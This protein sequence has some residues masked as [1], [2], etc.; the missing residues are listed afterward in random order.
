V[1]PSAKRQAIAILVD[2]HRVS[3]RRACQVVR[4]ARAAY[5]RPP[6]AAV[7][8]DAAVIEALTSLVARKPRWGFWK[9]FD[10]FHNQG[11]LWNHKRVYRVYCA[12]RLNLARR[13]KKRVPTRV[14]Q[15]LGAPAFVN[16][17]WA[18]DFMHD[19]LYDSRPFRTFNVLDEGNREA[20]A[21][22]VA[23][24]L[25]SWRVLAVLDELIAVHGA[26]AA[27]RLDNGPEFIAEAVAVWAAAQGIAL[28]FIQPG[29][30]DQNAYIERFNRTYREE[31]LDAHVFDSIGE[32]QAET[33]L[34]RQSYNTERPHDSLG[35]RPPLIFLPRSTS[36]SESTS[37]VST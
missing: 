10:R 9:C 23:T 32:V 21:I 17:T 15:P 31:V 4:L 24:S 14:R 30:P 1:T 28:R 29:K 8:R 3:V 27:L 2:E 16:Q 34:W 5:Y 13:T 20:L 19:R 35:G 11:Y 36:I 25:P 18:I 33:A 22:E 26:P 7:A 6:R 37:Q 12:L